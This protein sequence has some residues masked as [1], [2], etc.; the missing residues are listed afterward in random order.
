MLSVDFLLTSSES[1]VREKIE[2]L[3]TSSLLNCYINQK[4]V[5]KHSESRP[6]SIGTHRCCTKR[7]CP[8]ADSRCTGSTAA[9]SDVQ[10]EVV[11]QASDG[12]RGRQEVRK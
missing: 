2:A 7:Q 9:Y 4:H 3:N 11:A 10:G 6:Q 12:R 8:A 1:A 5:S